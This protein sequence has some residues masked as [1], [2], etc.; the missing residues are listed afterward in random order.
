MF[1]HLNRVF[2][3]KFTRNEHFSLLDNFTLKSISNYECIIFISIALVTIWVGNGND[4]K[5]RYQENRSDPAANLLAI[6]SKTVGLAN[7][8]P[9]K[10]RLSDFYG[11]GRR[12]C[13]RYAEDNF[14][15]FR[16]FCYNKF[17]KKQLRVLQLL[18]FWISRQN[19][20]QLHIDLRS[21]FFWLHYWLRGYVGA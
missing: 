3:Q 11:N 5:G 17:L 19:P 1:L 18:N 9:S 15:I 16:L 12:L 8:G 10:M 14:N 20:I 21:I 4:W 7:K 13:L 6:L 2:G